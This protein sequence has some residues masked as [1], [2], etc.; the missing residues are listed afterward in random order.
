MSDQHTEHRSEVFLSRLLTQHV[1]NMTHHNAPYS[2]ALA[3]RVV[4]QSGKHG[5][6]ALA[7]ATWQV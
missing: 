5:V 7:G 3:L 6:T 2:P 1:I 4:N